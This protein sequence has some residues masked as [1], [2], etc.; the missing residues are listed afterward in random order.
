MGLNVIC[1]RFW[2]SDSLLSTKQGLA[3]SVVNL[4][5][6]ATYKEHPRNGWKA[7][8]KE[9]AHMKLTSNTWAVTNIANEAATPEGPQLWT[10]GEPHFSAGARCGRYS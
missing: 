8:A 7:K 9:K 2:A 1:G 3:V 5:D 4:G 10:D 6:K